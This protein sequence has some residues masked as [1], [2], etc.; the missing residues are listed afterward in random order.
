MG[1]IRRSLNGK[2]LRGGQPWKPHARINYGN[3]LKKQFSEWKLK[4]SPF[5]PRSRTNPNCRTQKKPHAPVTPQKYFLYQ[6]SLNWKCVW[7]EGKWRKKKI[8]VEKEK[9]NC[10]PR[11]GA[12]VSAYCSDEAYTIAKSRQT[13]LI[14]LKLMI[15]LWT[16]QEQERATFLMATAILPVAHKYNHALTA[17]YETV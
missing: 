2:I 4:F 15:F 17:G 8:F 11:T 6:F 3:F 7:R 12:G 13:F 1:K 10:S 16:D 9:K 5:T 14:P